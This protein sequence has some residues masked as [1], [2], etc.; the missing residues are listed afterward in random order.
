MIKEIEEAKQEDIEQ[1]PTSSSS[2]VE[3]IDYKKKYEQA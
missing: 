2:I 1:L 3:S